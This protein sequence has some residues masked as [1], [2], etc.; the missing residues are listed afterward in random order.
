MVSEKRKES[1]KK[2]N[3]SISNESKQQYA[4][5]RLLM[6]LKDGNTKVIQRNTLFKYPW[7]DGEKNFLSKYLPD[8]SHTKKRELITQTIDNEAVEEMNFEELLH[9]SNIEK[10]IR[11]RDNYKPSN[12]GTSR[13]LS[14][15]TKINNV[16]QAKALCRMYGTEDFR[17]IFNDSPKELY[18]KLASYVIPNGMKNAGKTYEHSSLK[19][20]VEVLFILMKEYDPVI[21]YIKQKTYHDLDGYVKELERVSVNLQQN[22][23]SKTIEKLENNSTTDSVFENFKALFQLEATLKE[24]STKTL[25]NNLHYMTILLHTY[26]TFK[27][28]IEPRNVSFIPRLDYDKITLTDN[29]KNLLGNGKFYNYKTGR[30]YLKGVES[31]KQGG[32]YDFDYIV[33]KYVREQILTSI[34]AYPRMYLLGNYTPSTIGRTFKTL[35]GI[36]NTDYRHLIETV[37]TILKVDSVVLSNAMAHTPLTG[38][39]IYLENLV[40][41]YDDDKRQMIVD[42]FK[43]LAK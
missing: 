18:S 13:T 5:N 15:D 4:M 21:E 8:Q 23:E 2:Y 35:T 33:S 3:Q 14:E 40:D 29:N 10:Y 12:V 25:S 39:A 24:Q 36:T 20:K 37:Y 32:N 1:M 19:K 26:G 22:A 9:C 43:T 31:T 34:E 28:S 16:S 30:M 42:Y 17:L 41:K 6:R 27:K 11:T 38:K 7:S